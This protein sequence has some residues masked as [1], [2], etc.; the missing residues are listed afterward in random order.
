[1]FQMAKY[2]HAFACHQKPQPYTA[3]FNLTD[4]CNSRCITCTEWHKKSS[5]E[6]N[7]DELKSVLE[8][9]SHTS[10]SN[11]HF[12]GG[13]L[14]LRKDIF[15]LVEYAYDLGF[16]IAMVSNGLLINQENARK[17]VKKGVR[18]VCISIDGPEPIH[19]A[20]R[21]IK[22]AYQKTLCA[23]KAFANLKRETQ[24]LKVSIANTIMKPT[25]PTIL[26]SVELARKLDITVSFNL[27]D[28]KPYFFN[29]V[30]LKDLWISDHQKLNETLNQL[31]EIKK[32]N[33]SL[34]G[35][36]V[37]SLEYAKQYFKD[38]LRRD[39]PCYLGFIELFIGAKGDVFPCWALKPVGSVRKTCLK[40]ILESRAYRDKLNDM[41]A[42]NCPGCSCGYIPNLD[43][44][45]S[46]F[47][48]EF[49]AL[50]HYTMSRVLAR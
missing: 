44:D 13:E 48:K 15:D 23:V 9:L 8:Q 2:N 50:P 40:D 11:V 26:H 38:P 6:M 46:A 33:P 35:N 1:M 32:R 45:L 7:T 41:W 3:N 34:I 21:G 28:S 16:N 43:F 18:G 20:V 36:N 47:S 17:L 30:D 4:N 25:L 49:S 10:V 24:D 22:G 19:D 12:G 5:N 29:G 39:I 27:I 14:M 31:I 37:Q 42:K